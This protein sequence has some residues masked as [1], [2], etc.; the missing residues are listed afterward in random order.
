MTAAT[1]GDEIYTAAAYITGRLRADTGMGGLFEAAVAVGTGARVSGAYETEAPQ[2]AA[3][4]YIVYQ[5]QGA[6]DIR[7]VGGL[8]ATSVLYLVRVVVAGAAIG[9]ARLAAKRLHQVLELTAGTI[10]AGLVSSC[11]REQ[12]YSE[13]LTEEDGTQ[14]RY[15]GGT[16]RLMVQ[17]T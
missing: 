1:T 15:H 16:Y 14:H 7:P 5:F 8:L 2:S 9:P 13:V 4:P 3:L 11:A 10:T 6:A 17:S 12:P